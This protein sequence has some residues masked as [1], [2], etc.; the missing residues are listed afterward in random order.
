[1]SS[2]TMFGSSADDYVLNKVLNHY[3]PIANESHVTKQ[4]ALCAL[5]VMRTTRFL[6]LEIHP[7]KVLVE[8]A[9]SLSLMPPQVD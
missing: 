3:P 2:S 1:M 4:T 9:W 7:L 6:P 8:T 5:D